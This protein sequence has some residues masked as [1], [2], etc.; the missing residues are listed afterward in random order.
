M[1]KFAVVGCGNIA[2]KSVIPAILKSEHCELAVCIHRNADKKAELVAAYG[3]DF[4]TSLEEA[5]QLYAFDAVY[6][7]T[8]IGLH[9]ESI[10]I[11]ANAGKHILCEKSLVSELEDAH[12]VVAACSSNGV[13]LFEGFMYQFHTQH[14]VVRK[15]I[16][17][18]A[19]GKPF[20]FQ[21][22]FG[23][24]PIGANDFRY[25][26]QLGG[27][28]LLDAGSYTIH[29]ARHF[30]DSEPAQV[31]AV[32]ENE[33][34]EVETRATIM[35]DFGASRT[36]HL[37]CGFNNMYQNKYEIWGTTGKL[38]L[39]RAFA[40]PPNFSST[41]VIE[42]QGQKEE[43]A[44]PQCDHFKEEL[45]F[46]V[47]HCSDLEQQQIWYKEILNQAITIHKVFKSGQQST[48]H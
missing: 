11:A 22:W 40:V 25:N 32:L 7:S 35:L 47:L 36:A 21:A 1:M 13:A 18:G 43:V 48:Q 12:Q 46:F 8:P 3:C 44:M 5:L 31:F 30:F 27:G 23:F 39:S 9:K 24:P 42:Q 2:R 16:A 10:L 33:G 37:V 29:A 19:I 34:T 4:A 17:D 14:Q 38:S 45:D 28:A 41:L 6:I 20:H 15:M 26:K